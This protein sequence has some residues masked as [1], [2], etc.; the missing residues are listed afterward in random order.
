MAQMEVDVVG[1]TALQVQ[2]T[3]RVPGPTPRTNGRSDDVF[4]ALMAKIPTM[5]VSRM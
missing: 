2:T 4:D 5:S 3:D 1:S